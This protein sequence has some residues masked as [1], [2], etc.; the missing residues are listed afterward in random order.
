MSAGDATNLVHG[1]VTALHPDVPAPDDDGSG[2]PVLDW[3]ASGAMA[4][5]GHAGRPPLISPADSFGM[6]AAVSRLLGW[7]TARTGA[8]V[9]PDPGALLSGR[10]GLLGLTRNGRVSAGGST[11]LLRAADGWCAVTLS[12]PDDADSVPAILGAT[13]ISDP[14]RALASATRTRPARA[15]A[16]RA[17]LLGVPASALPPRQTIVAASQPRIQLATAGLAAGRAPNAHQQAASP[18]QMTRLAGRASAAKLSGATVVDLSSMWA[19]PLCAQLLGQA[20]ADVIKVE[21][22][23][24][25]DGARAGEPRFFDWLHVGHRSVTID[26]AS[27]SGRSAL[28][29]LLRS[30]HVVIETSRPRALEQLGL[31]PGTLDHRAGQVWLSVTGYGRDAGE[32]VAFGDDA[33][34]AGGLVGWDCDE[35]VFC[36]DAVADPLA[37]ICGALA[38]ASSLAAGGG[39]LIDLSM[40]AVAAAFAAA[41]AR[42][43]GPHVLYSGEAVECQRLGRVQPVLPPRIPEPV[44]RAAAPGADTGILASLAGC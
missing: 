40:R 37:G 17:Q 5:T 9:R 39:T 34:V 27:R 30:A 7:A 14:W 26:F 25:P 41:P 43:P 28:A 19:G 10:A 11:R 12:R 31:A 23:S 16:D 44:G 13:G 1:W 8:A 22:A 15:L 24:R 4:L 18:W 6:L 38:V 2:C 35:P 3:A 21:S 36:A 42:C 29:A 20:G 32:R 33:A